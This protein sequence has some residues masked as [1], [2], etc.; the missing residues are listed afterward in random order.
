MRGRPRCNACSTTPQTPPHV[1]RFLPALFLQLLHNMDSYL[2]FPPRCGCW[3]SNWAK[4]FA[5]ALLAIGYPLQ[6][7]QDNME[8]I[9]PVAIRRLLSERRSSIFTPTPDNLD[10]RICP[11]QGVI[12][13]TYARWFQKPPWAIVR[14]PPLH[15]PL[16][17][18]I[19][20]LFFRF[21]AGCRGL[22]IDTGRR[23]HPSPPPLVLSVAA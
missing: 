15:L 4:S 9:D 17:P 14:T 3:I 22:P 10:P 23:T 13:C 7:E 20:R 2:L 11:S 16:P 1:S 21:R 8:V 6:L 12:V 18:K 5:Q 19:L